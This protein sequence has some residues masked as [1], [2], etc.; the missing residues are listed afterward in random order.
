MRSNALSAD[1]VMLNSDP[2][3][4]LASVST[5]TLDSCRSSKRVSGALF[6]VMS[7]NIDVVQPERVDAGP[8]RRRQPTRG[9]ARR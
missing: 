2:R 8:R 4:A 5:P 7:E 1:T 3:E 9:S 6:W